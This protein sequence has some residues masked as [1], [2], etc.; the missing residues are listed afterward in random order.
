M[1]TATAGSNRAPVRGCLQ[2]FCF[3][4]FREWDLRGRATSGTCSF[5]M[6]P[7]ESRIYPHRG[8]RRATAESAGQCF[9]YYG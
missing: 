3:Q 1:T 5:G 4:W 7:R 2:A 6:R 9:D 8:R